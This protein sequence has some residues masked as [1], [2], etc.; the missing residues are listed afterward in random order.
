MRNRLFV[1]SLLFSLF[2]ELFSQAPRS[3]QVVTVSPRGEVQTI[4][5]VQM[6]VATF[7]QAMTALQEAPADESTGPLIITPAIPGKYRWQGTSTFSFIP[8]K[9]LPHA[10]AY[11]T[12]RNE[13]G[14]RPDLRIGS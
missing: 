13:I 1:S 9:P 2:S 14:D 11:T 7:N 8:G 6:I 10:T 3:L 4:D 12:C 5:Q